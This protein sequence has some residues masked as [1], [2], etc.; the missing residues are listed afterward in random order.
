MAAA[1]GRAI[2]VAH[3]VRRLQRAVQKIAQFYDPFRAYP[4]PIFAIPG[5]HDGIIYNASMKSLDSFEQA[6]CTPNPGRWTGSGG[7]RRSSMTQPGVYFTLDAPLVSIIGLYSNC[8]KSLGWLNDQQL[9]FLYQELVRLKGLRKSGMPAV[10][11]AIHH[12]PRWFPGQKDQ[13]AT[14]SMRPARRRA[15]GPMR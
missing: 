2:E 3:L 5:N 12:F 11:L 10:I 1:V 9:I 14:Q 4:A 7:I 8:G 6:F 13:P 15:F